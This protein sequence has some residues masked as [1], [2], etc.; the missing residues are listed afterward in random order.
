M[1]NGLSYALSEREMLTNYD[2]ANY[3]NNLK[4]FKEGAGDITAAII[5]SNGS[6]HIDL[7]NSNLNTLEDI[8]IEAEE[9]ADFFQ[10]IINSPKLNDIP[11]TTKVYDTSLIE[12]IRPEAL[13]ME[14]Q[15]ITLNIT[16][17]IQGKISKRDIESVYM[18]PASVLTLK[19]QLVKM[20]IPY[21]LQPKDMYR[22]DGSVIVNVDSQF[23][24]TTLLPFLNGAVPTIKSLGVTSA[25]T[26]AAINNSYDVIRNAVSTLDSL[27]KSDKISIKDYRFLSSYIYKTTRD[28]MSA[29][30]FLTF[31]LIKK[32]SSIY[33]NIAA[34][35]ELQGKILNYFPEGEAVLHESVFDNSAEY[36]DIDN[37]RVVNSMVMG[38]PSELIGMM[39][40]AYRKIKSDMDFAEL[41]TD[42]S[43]VDKDSVSIAYDNAIKMVEEIS[44]GLDTLVANVKDPLM[45]F[46]DIVDKCGFADP[47]NKR[48]AEIISRIS[49]PKEY[50]DAELSMDNKIEIIEVGI[51]ELKYGQ[52]KIRL[53]SE[54]LRQLYDKIQDL[55]GLFTTAYSAVFPNP[56]NI[57][58]A[59]EFITPF[60][61]DFRQFVNDLNRAF[62]TRIKSI[63]DILAAIEE[64]N[65]TNREVF[66]FVGESDYEGVFDDILTESLMEIEDMS[67]ITEFEEYIREYHK[68]RTY[69]ET[70]EVVMYEDELLAT[71][72]NASNNGNTNDNKPNVQGAQPASNTLGDKLKNLVNAFKAFFKKT[73][74]A[75]K[76]IIVKQSK[77]LSILEQNREKILSSDFS[78]TT[79]TIIPYEKYFSMDTLLSDMDKLA[80]NVSGL[81]KESMAT[82]KD[83]KQL[84]A[85]L[86]NFMTNNL[87]NSSN[88]S[89]PL[90]TYYKTKGAA[91][92]ASKY[93]GDAAK[94]LLETALDYTIGYYKEN[95]K[96]VTDKV[97]KITKA[98]EAKCTQFETLTESVVLEA[99][100]DQNNT[101]TQNTQQNSNNDKA[102]K[103]SVTTINPDTKKNEAKVSGSTNG[104]IYDILKWTS[105][106]CQ[107]YVSAVCTT[108]RDINFEY[109]KIIK[110]FM[111]KDAADNTNDNSQSENNTSDEQ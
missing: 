72:P 11:I 38:N 97:D 74:D 23:I 68:E 15:T 55:R 10:K 7:I 61:S 109:L 2:R 49:T 54:K 103:P 26:I 67:V 62:I 27:F 98:C 60:E 57:A 59:A 37:D 105:Q 108:T 99:D 46:D 82:I 78:N 53:V 83:Q 66:G 51:N 5:T 84:N 44:R 18:S 36:S 79:I 30:S 107:Y 12:K 58:R 9:I 80:E 104:G 35:R 3:H 102:D 87:G 52:D 106:A 17:Y 94:K 110:P 89:E 22:Y 28:F 31:A 93:S 101:Q 39:D 20:K 88:I 69:Y 76:E 42:W 29:T 4:F 40:Y 91:L 81:T 92:K 43:S 71:S 8:G 86:F 73:T 21:D 32:M 56:Q 13:Y 16:K 1:L 6:M 25:N 48:F 75:M 96:A 24:S 100:G 19:K 47:L 85:K 95:N 70:G 41:G 65:F 111:P 64:D 50:A 63:A 45:A 77:N 90:K 34:Y 14:A 33:G